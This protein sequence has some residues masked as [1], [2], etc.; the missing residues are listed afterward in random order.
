M[1]KLIK[2]VYHFFPFEWFQ[3]LGLPISQI[4]KV[5]TANYQN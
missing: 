5:K 4:K 2:I 3:N 1:D